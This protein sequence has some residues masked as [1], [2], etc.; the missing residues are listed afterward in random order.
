M[1]KAD[2]YL[3][4]DIHNMWYNPLKLIPVERM[5]AVHNHNSF[6]LMAGMDMYMCMRT[7]QMRFGMCKS[8]LSTR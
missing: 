2:K 5:T 6:A 7:M 8:R 1:T 3:I 4:D